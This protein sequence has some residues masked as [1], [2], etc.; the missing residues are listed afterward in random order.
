[1]TDPHHNHGHDSHTA[2]GGGHEIDAPPTRE[3][4]NI[5]WGLGLLTL[6][7]LV[8][9]VQL[10]NNQAREIG[11]DRGKEGSYVLADYRKDAETRTRGSGQDSVTD[12][13][14]KVV[15]K[16]NY[17]PLASARELVLGKPEKLGAFAPPPGWI[18]P[19]DVAAGG[20]G[21]GTPPALPQPTPT[22][23][24]IGVGQPGQPEGTP[25]GAAAGL[26]PVEPTPGQPVG[27][28][29][30]TNTGAGQAPGGTVEPVGAKSPGPEAKLPDAASG[31]A[32]P[33]GNRPATEPGHGAPTPSDKA[34]P[35][36]VGEA[37]AE[38]AK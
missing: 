7:S 32:P 28:P 16:Y 12:A 15:G 10:F 17:I 36:P 9:C 13:T 14:G 22:G 21:A 2:H 27:A 6:L 35:Q 30:Q 19:D 38:P 5:V 23:A 1:M 29:D 8:T 20:Q 3:L 33:A 25:T 18:H 26:P 31:S 24:G 34:Q 4:F 37:K 11:A